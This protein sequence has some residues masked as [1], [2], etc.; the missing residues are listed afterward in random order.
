MIRFASRNIQTF[1]PWLRSSRFASTLTF[2]ETTKEGAIVPSSLSALNAAQQLGNDITALLLGSQA[3]AAA[4]LL[5]SSVQC[6]KL[7]KVIVSGDTEYDHYLPEK[8]TPL[9]VDLLKG[10][11]YS[12]FVVASSAVGKNLLPRV[13]A[14]LDYQPVCDIIKIQSPNTFVRPIYAGNAIET[15]ENTQAKTLLSVRASAFDA[16]ASGSSES[17]SIENVDTKA[18]ATGEDVEWEK[19]N[20]I[21]N[22]RPDLS[23]ASIVVSG[24]RA[25]KD[26]ATFDK[27]LLP[28]ADVLKAGIGATRAAVDS[29][30]CDNS[31]QIGQT[32]KVVAPDLYIAV[33]I[34]GAIQHLAGMKDSKK[35]VAI[36]ND[37]DAPI[38]K[39]ADYG[40]EGDIYEV[41]PELTDKLKK[42]Q[43]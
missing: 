39:V 42:L 17:A 13:S 11:D 4:N 2:I 5:K 16:I 3:A 32:G 25:L 21:K 24:G 36:N 35:I 22:E 37:P 18:E 38:Y 29:G 31:L 7:N 28:L 15:V 40:L 23:S 30:F 6:S 1:K 41:V 26:K 27:I 19:S 43:H 8:I 20:L 14:L 34:S 10:E 33:G 9:V 12:H